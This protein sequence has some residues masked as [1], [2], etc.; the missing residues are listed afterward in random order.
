MYSTSDKQVLH[1]YSVVRLSLED[2]RDSTVPIGVVAWDTTNAWYGW[3]WLENDEKVRGVDA[4]NRKLMRITENQ[5]QRWAHAR[6]VP[7][8]PAPVEPTSARFWR[9]VSE[10]L[11]TAVRLD[12]PRAMEPMDE[13]DAQ[14][15]ALFEALVQPTQPKKHRLQ[16][17]DSAVKQALGRWADRIP[18]NPRVSAF[19]GAK[20]QVRRGLTTARGIL[21]VDGVNLAA[22]KARKEA[23]ALVSRFMRIR[24]A[25]PNRPVKIIVGYSSSPGGLNGEAHM[26]DWIRET[27]TSQVFD[28]AAQ[29]A[30]FRKAAADAWHQLQAKPQMALDGLA[31]PKQ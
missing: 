11:S 31:K 15:E 12:L 21:L 16:R 2:H 28:M 7:Y 9:A 14:I 3:R 30:E 19:G 26:R 1:G 25:Y 17:I 5:I 20:E 4:G 18:P 8:E 29:N 6:K 13:P 23:D 24:E 27:L 22:K 10:I